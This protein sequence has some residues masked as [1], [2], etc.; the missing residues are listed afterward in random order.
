MKRLIPF[1]LALA[2][3]A[4]LVPAALAV[5]NDASPVV[6]W[7]APKFGAIIATK[8]H[9]ALYTWKKE[10]DKKVHCTGACAKAW[11]PLI[12]PAN[13]MA[14]VHPHVSGVMGTFGVIHRPDGKA[15][16]TLNRKPLYSFSGDAPGQ[17][18]CDGVDGWHVVH[19]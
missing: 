4:V 1:L 10:S 5:S 2:A 9:L 7:N 3:T 11:P 14:M 12:V 18:K 16:L 17:V 19:A 15:Q 13:E 8:G 6:K